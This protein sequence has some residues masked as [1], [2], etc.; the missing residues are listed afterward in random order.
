MLQARAAGLPEGQNLCVGRT[1]PSYRAPNGP[2]LLSLPHP[3]TKPHA[4]LQPARQHTKDK[5][6]AREHP[7]SRTRCTRITR[8]RRVPRQSAGVRA[9]RGPRL[10]ATHSAQPHAEATTGSKHK[11][12]RSSHPPASRATASG[13]SPPAAPTTALGPLQLYPKLVP[14]TPQQGRDPERG[15]TC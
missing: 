5:A 10:T 6:G 15:S 7:P 14:Q 1:V 2:H 11:N 12:K 4:Q 8:H 3:P 9:G 13:D